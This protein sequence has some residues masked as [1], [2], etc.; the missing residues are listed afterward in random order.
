MLVEL[1]E[2]VYSWK[3]VLITRSHLGSIC[4]VFL[5]QFELFCRTS[6]SK[7]VRCERL[8][9]VLTKY[10]RVSADCRIAD[11][12][13]KELYLPVQVATR[14]GSQNSRISGA[15]LRQVSESIV[16]KTCPPSKYQPA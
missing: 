12:L 7:A 1:F 6:A 2:A 14:E 11:V 8:S 4:C 15:H 13:F 10:I 3:K 16:D 5:I 9:L